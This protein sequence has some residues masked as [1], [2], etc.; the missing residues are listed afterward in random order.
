MPWR[1][2]SPALAPLLALPEPEQSAAVEDALAKHATARAQHEKLEG[3]QRSTAAALTLAT[4]KLDEAR[5]AHGETAKS[6]AA[7]QSDLAA[8]EASLAAANTQRASAEKDHADRMAA[9]AA[10]LQQ[11]PDAGAALERDASAF[12]DSFITQ[13]ESLRRLRQQVDEVMSNITPDC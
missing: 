13:V 7:Q 1:P 11:L 2:E 8:A 3:D 12:A 9:L 6:L 10:L 4:R 5:A